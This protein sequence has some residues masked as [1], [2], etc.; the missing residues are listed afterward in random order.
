MRKSLEEIYLEHG[1]R[2]RNERGFLINAIDLLE[3][4]YL[5]LNPEEFAEIEDEIRFQE[6]MFRI[7]KDEKEKGDWTL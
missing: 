3:I 2:I 5:R 4:I 7:F 6:T 1:V